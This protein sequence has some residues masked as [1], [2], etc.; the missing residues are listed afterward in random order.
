MLNFAKC[1]S[2]IPIPLPGWSNIP[3]ERCIVRQRCRDRSA[4]MQ[5]P[6]LEIS[7]PSRRN[8]LT[9]TRMELLWCGVEFA[10]YDKPALISMKKWRF[11]AKLIFRYVIVCNSD[12]FSNGSYCVRLWCG[13]WHNLVMIGTAKVDWNLIFSQLVF[14]LRDRG[15]RLVPRFRVTPNR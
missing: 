6:Q 3:H 9:E 14:S 10:H 1:P 4:G 7:S 11:V 5:S 13:S 12:R 8:I 15:A 2:S